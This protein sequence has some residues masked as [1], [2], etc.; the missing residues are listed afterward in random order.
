[1][2]TQI[3]FIDNKD[4]SW[5]RNTFLN[6]CRMR[7]NIYRRLKMRVESGLGM[8]QELTEQDAKKDPDISANTEEITAIKSALDKVIEAI[9]AY[10]AKIEEE[11]TTLRAK[12]YAELLKQHQAEVEAQN[13]QEQVE[14]VPEQEQTVESGT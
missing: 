12:N 2:S 13:A 11:Y 9:D 6:N 7:S 10:G 14:T 1:M 8:C 3:E 4:A 5:Y